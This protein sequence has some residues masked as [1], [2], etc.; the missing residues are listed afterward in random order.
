[1]S[2]QGS[3]FSVWCLVCGVYGWEERP[4]GRED[5]WQALKLGFSVQ[6]LDFRVWFLVS[7]V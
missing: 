2:V 1:M 5:L 4:E 6:R 3:G 7:T